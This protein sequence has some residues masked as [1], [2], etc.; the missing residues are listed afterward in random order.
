[1]PDSFSRLVNEYPESP[2]TERVKVIKKIQ[3]QLL[4]AKG[5]RE[6]LAELQGELQQQLS[7]LQKKF[8]ECVTEKERLTGEVRSRDE[9]LKELDACRIERERLVKDVRSLER[10]TLKLKSLLSESGIVEPAPPTR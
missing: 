6:Q 8:D 9:K 5:E 2:W 10:Y 7:Q 3:R 4:E 1:M